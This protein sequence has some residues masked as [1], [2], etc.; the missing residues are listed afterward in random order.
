M[1]VMR[2]VAVQSYNSCGGEMVNGSD[3]IGGGRVI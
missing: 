1:G 2:S 3:E